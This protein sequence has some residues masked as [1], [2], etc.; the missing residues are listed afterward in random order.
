ML[1]VMGYGDQDAA[2]LRDGPVNHMRDTRKNRATA[3][4]SLPYETGCRFPWARR[5]RPSVRSQPVR[6][7]CSS[8]AM[9]E[10]MDSAHRGGKALPTRRSWRPG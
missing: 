2:A 5:G 6:T 1:L 3:A 7:S 10:A 9:W 8:V 4:A